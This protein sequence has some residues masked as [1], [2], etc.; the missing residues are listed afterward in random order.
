M[1][2]SL[3]VLSEQAEIRRQVWV[4]VRREWPLDGWEKEVPYGKPLLGLGQSGV[5]LPG[6]LA[7]LGMRNAVELRLRIPLAGDVDDVV[8]M[9]FI[10]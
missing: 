2:T 5:G 7:A 1:P 8:L 10:A 9:D 6:Q 4:N 3:P